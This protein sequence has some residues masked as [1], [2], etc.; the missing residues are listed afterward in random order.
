MG[1]TY[2]SLSS[3]GATIPAHFSLDRGI[4]QPRVIQGG[5]VIIESH[6]QVDRAAISDCLKGFFICN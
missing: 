1:L 3:N 5:F 4:N 2:S 6:V